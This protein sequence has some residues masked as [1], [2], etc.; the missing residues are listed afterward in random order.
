MN[1]REIQQPAKNNT[2]SEVAIQGGQ[3]VYNLCG[4]L[5]SKTGKLAFVKNAPS[6][7]SII[8]LDISTTTEK[9]RIFGTVVTIF[10][11]GHNVELHTVYFQR[12]KKK[13]RSTH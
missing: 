6:D 3:T 4:V 1:A 5:F 8:V 11:A 12:K 9:W 7:I 2:A 13:K 10:C